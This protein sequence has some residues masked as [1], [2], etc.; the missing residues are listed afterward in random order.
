MLAEHSLF[1]AESVNSIVIT[2]GYAGMNDDQANLSPGPHPLGARSTVMSCL[3]S[4]L[5]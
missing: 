4:G 3:L 1:R 5:H 2:S